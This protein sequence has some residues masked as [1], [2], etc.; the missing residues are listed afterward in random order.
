MPAPGNNKP[1]AIVRTGTVGTVVHGGP[2]KPPATSSRR[3]RKQRRQN[4]Q[5]KQKKTRR[6]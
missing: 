3:S 4:K 2:N 1:P 5:K 6:V